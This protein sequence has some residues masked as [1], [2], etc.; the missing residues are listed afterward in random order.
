MASS[1][2]NSIGELIVLAQ[3][4]R[5]V[6]RGVTGTAELLGM[7]PRSLNRLI[8]SDA[9]GDAV[10]T[11]RE[12]MQVLLREHNVDVDTP[13]TE[14]P[15]PTTVRGWYYLGLRVQPALWV[16][17]SDCAAKVRVDRHLLGRSVDEQ[18]AIA[19]GDSSKEA[20]A[21][22]ALLKKIDDYVRPHLPPPPPKEP[23]PAPQVDSTK[24]DVDA[25]S[26]VTP[27]PVEQ[28]QAFVVPS[29]WAD[30][31]IAGRLEAASGKDVS[32]VRFL[33]TQQLLAKMQLPGKFSAEENKDTNKLI[34][35]LLAHLQ[36]DDLLATELVRRLQVGA[37]FESEKARMETIRKLFQNFRVLFAR[38]AQMRKHWDAMC[39]MSEESEWPAYIRQD[40]DAIFRLL[41]QS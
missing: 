17:Y 6:T 40:M 27:S 34:E 13:V 39:D 21:H 9:S 8:H 5:V 14:R 20:L 33:L 12:T 2:T 11:I 30:E 24:T 3:E 38:V 4:H 7:P 28:E 10:N 1:G 31:L 25:T 41:S 26:S 35:T 32:K 37:N 36:H 18:S 23:T 29:N 15:L 19:D 16:N 22:R